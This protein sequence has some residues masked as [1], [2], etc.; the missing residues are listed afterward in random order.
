MAST[1]TLSAPEPERAESGYAKS[2]DTRARILAAALEEAGESGFH[3]TSVAAIAKR[4]GVAIGSLHYHFGSRAELIRELM[5]QLMK[6][7]MARVMSA[8]AESGGDY[9]SRERA[10]ILAYVGLVRR[11]PDFVRLADEIRLQEPELYRRG[12]RR[13]V[14]RMAQRI[15]T[16]IEEGTLRPMGDAKI[17]LKAQL[18]IN[19]RHALEELALSDST[20]TDE[21]VVDAFLE[22]ER[23]GIGARDPQRLRA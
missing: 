7:Y 1:P 11:Q 22:F 9:F 18:L 5:E 3:K 17:Q 13:F 10:T 14:E 15:R 16:G 4:A 8:E 19:A 23:D 21:A 2:R 6:I 12:Q 20:L